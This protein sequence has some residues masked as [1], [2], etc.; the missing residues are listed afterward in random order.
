MVSKSPCP[1]KSFSPSSEEV[2]VEKI[3]S[4]HSSLA[5]RVWI[6]LVAL[7]THRRVSDL[8]AER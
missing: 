4:I 8:G 5:K 2:L 3:A 6:A 7:V 1:R